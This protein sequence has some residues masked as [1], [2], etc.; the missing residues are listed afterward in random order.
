VILAL[1]LAAATAGPYDTICLLTARSTATAVVAREAGVP[2]D[3][4]MKVLDDITDP[5]AH[6]LMRASMLEIYSQPRV[7]EPFDEDEF[8]STTT[9]QC[10]LRLERDAAAE[11]VRAIPTSVPLHNLTGVK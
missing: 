10:I 2:L 11:P 1:V 8:I 7:G 3:K 9:A 5:T 6:R 4:V